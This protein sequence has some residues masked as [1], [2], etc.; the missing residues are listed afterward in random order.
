MAVRIERPADGWSLPAARQRPRAATRV[1]LGALGAIVAGMLAF[2]LVLVGTGDRRKTVAVAV[3]AHDIAPG[4]LVTPADVRRV[5]LPADSPLLG[6]LVAGSPPEAGLVAT[7]RIAEGEPLGR[8][9]LV[10]P[11][12]GGGLRAMS[13]AVPVERAVGGDLSAG[14]RVD[15]VD[16]SVDPASYVARDLEVLA[17]SISNGA[18]GSATPNAVTVAVDDAGAL[19]LAGAVARGKVDLVRSTGATHRTEQPASAVST[20]TTRQARTARP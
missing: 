18:L 7:H 11:A 19:A 13:L 15:V 6:S 14:D 4:Q 2:L 12:A 8:S 10:A 3:A 20:S 5:A 1:P 9:S 17:V 16:S